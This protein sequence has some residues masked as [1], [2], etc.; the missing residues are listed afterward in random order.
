MLAHRDTQR[1]GD[2]DDGAGQ[3]VAE[4]R[5][6]IPQLQLDALATICRHV[7]GCDAA[8]APTAG[9]TVV[10]RT[11]LEALETGIGHATIDGLAQPVSI[12]TLRRMAAAGAVIPCVLGGD[13]E[14]LDFGRTR[15]LFSPAQKLALI[16]R[17]GGCAMCGLP[18]GMTQV[19]HLRWWL[20]DAGPT[21]LRNGILLCI[22]CHHR[23]HDDGWTIRIDGNGVAAKVWFTPPVHV[24]PSRKE[25]LGGR[26]RFDYAA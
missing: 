24:D 19:H 26:A 20:R 7:L 3:D 17:D 5:R 14:I 1:A 6:S 13:S 11:T 22:R 18:P 2:R 9:A 4:D 8:D 10:A 16:E 15:R 23:I 12:T 25:R 21:D